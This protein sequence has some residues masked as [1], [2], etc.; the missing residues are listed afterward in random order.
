MLVE[1]PPLEV[2]LPESLLRDLRIE[3]DQRWVSWEPTL[4]DVVLDRAGATYQI[5]E[6]P[7]GGGR[8]VTL[9]GTSRDGRYN[10]GGT[11]A[12][13][14]LRNLGSQSVDEDARVRIEIS[15]QG[16]VERPRVLVSPAEFVTAIEEIID[17]LTP[18]NRLQLLDYLRGN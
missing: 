7:L 9:S 16:D 13:T 18:E 5:A 15:N 17:L 4:I 3:H 11:V 6:L 8:S 14:A 10:L 1:P 2:R 12:P